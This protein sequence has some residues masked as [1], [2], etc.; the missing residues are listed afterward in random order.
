MNLASDPFGWAVNLPLDV[1]VPEFRISW[2][3]PVRRDDCWPRRTYRIPIFID[4]G[5]DCRLE[6]VREE[7]LPRHVDE[8]LRSVVGEPAE[9]RPSHGDSPYRLNESA[10][11]ELYRHICYRSV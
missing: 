4:T 3:L 10:T 8:S 7:G 11:Q 6:D 5:P 9:L 1:T 2:L